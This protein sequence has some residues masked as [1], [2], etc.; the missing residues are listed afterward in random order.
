[1]HEAFETFGKGNDSLLWMATGRGRGILF[2]PR[3][4]PCPRPCLNRSEVRDGDS[5]LG[6]FPIPAPIPILF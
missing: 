3:P 5:P 4:H 2:L 6:D 1:M